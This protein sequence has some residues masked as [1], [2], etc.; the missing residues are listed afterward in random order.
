MMGSG[1][2]AVGSALAAATGWPYLDNDD[3]VQR[4]SGETAR[5]ILAAR[6]EGPMRETESRALATAL[7]AA[8]PCIVGAAAGV[9]LDEESCR[10][11]REAGT[12][13]WLRAR[14]STLEAR[15][16]RGEHRPW[17]DGADGRTWI[18]EATAARERVYASV[19]DI[20]VD[21]DDRSPEQIAAVILERLRTS[22]TTDTS[23]Q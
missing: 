2:S 1:K 9:V 6:G 23:R 20:T 7:E 19:A 10:R 14:A 15:A 17:I 18:G 13:V 3:I 8:A 21:V 11:L 12:V 22:R 16:M 4:L 5:E